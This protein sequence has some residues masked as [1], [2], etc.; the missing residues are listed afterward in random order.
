MGILWIIISTILGS[1]GQ[2]LLKYGMNAN[3]AI[4]QLKSKNIFIYYI[5]IIF[6]PLIIAGL[7]CYAVSMLVWLYVLTKYELSYARPF[8]ALGYVII[9]VYS[10]LFMNE[11]MNWMRWGG[12]ILIT[13]GVFL[14]AKS[15]DF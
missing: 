2:I 9:A 10:G 6:S 13:V 14:V 7:L 12:I 8:V 15:I 5:K 3:K 4:E 1:A 11:N